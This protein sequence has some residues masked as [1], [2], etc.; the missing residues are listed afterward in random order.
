MGAVGLVP[1][2]SAA[3]NGLPKRYRATA[4]QR[5]L[6]FQ[7][8]QLIAAWGN[9]KG[10]FVLNLPI[11]RR[12]RSYVFHQI[13]LVEVTVLPVLCDVSVRACRSPDRDGHDFRHGR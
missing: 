12:G 7:S 8:I 11:N 2:F 5:P 10:Q 4:P 1:T 9:T 6:S 13:A 3:A